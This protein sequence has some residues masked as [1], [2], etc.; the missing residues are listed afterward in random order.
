MKLAFCGIIVCLLYSHTHSQDI[1]L[2]E[3]PNPIKMRAEWHN[4]NGKWDFVFDS[5]NKGINENW[6]SGN[7]KFDQKIMVPF[8]WGSPLSEV[9]DDSDIGWYKRTINI[10]DSWKNK[11]TFL[12]IGASDWETH[13]WLDEKLIGSHQGGYI[14]FEFDLT[15]H[16]EY[17]QDQTLVIRADDTRRVFTLY[18]K[19]GYGNARGIWQT[20]YL[21]SRGNEYISDVQ[22]TPDID[23]QWVDIKTFLPDAVKEEKMVSILINGQEGPIHAQA[24]FKKGQREARTRVAISNP[25]LWTLE[26]PFLYDL[27]A[28][29][30]G[31]LLKTYF[32][33]RKISVMD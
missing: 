4:L 16:L 5:E 28:T 11:R 15:H 1:P 17:G 27:E 33:M 8:P 2:P 18:G 12:I 21:E 14:P 31:D 22:V 30:G 25:R 13:V 6:A 19:Q 23:S 7:A 32:G 24:K 29:M 10:S 3:H 9:D 20:V 26:D